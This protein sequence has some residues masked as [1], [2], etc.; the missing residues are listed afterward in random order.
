MV[1][2]LCPSPRWANWRYPGPLESAIAWWSPP[3]IDTGTTHRYDPAVA[4]FFHYN[5][6]A[7]GIFRRNHLPTRGIRTG[8]SERSI[9]VRACH[10]VCS[11]RW[12]W[13]RSA[14]NLTAH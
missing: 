1:G 11:V 3:A 4:G 2:A 14:L 8:G 7:E 10:V 13:P 9:L 6:L 5:P 12:A